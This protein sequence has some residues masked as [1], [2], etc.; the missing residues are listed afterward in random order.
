MLALA[1]LVLYG[2]TKTY[3]V[4]KRE[5]ARKTYEYELL[6]DYYQN[7]QDEV[8]YLSTDEGVEDRARE[9]YGWVKEGEN[10]ALVSGLDEDEN[11]D[12]EESSVE[13][14]PTGTAVRAP[15]TWYSGFLDPFFGYENGE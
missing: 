5:E 9:Q 1:G 14:P 11:S 10:A 4:A 13:A 2:P 8:E 3:Y 15:A 12:E 6:N 7:L